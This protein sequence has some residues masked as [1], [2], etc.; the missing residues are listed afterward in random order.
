MVDAGVT[1]E[2]V[3]P[4]APDF[5]MA[6]KAYGVEGQRLTAVADLAQA[7]AAAAERKGP[8]LIEIHERRTAGLSA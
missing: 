4:S 3:R 1:P 6:A 7:L 2:G 5:L 8:S